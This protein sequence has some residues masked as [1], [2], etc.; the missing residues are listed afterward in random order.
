[1][2]P[3]DEAVTACSAVVVRPGERVLVAFNTAVTAEEAD[4]VRD[5]LEEA[6]PYN[7]FAILDQVSSVSVFRQVP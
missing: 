5:R 3:T 6:F 1:M 2:H 4:R 7:G